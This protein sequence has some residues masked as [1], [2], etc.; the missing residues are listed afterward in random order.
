VH[1]VKHDGYRL[2]VH[3]RAGRVRLYSMNAADW[4]ERY[5]RIVKEAASSSGTRY[6]IAKRSARMRVAGQTLIG[7]IAGALSMRR[8]PAPSIF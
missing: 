1:E 4:T 5:P 2:Q 7:C 6:S 8:L 3:V